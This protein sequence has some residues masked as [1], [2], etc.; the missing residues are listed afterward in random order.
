MDLERACAVF[1]SFWRASLKPVPIE[2]HVIPEH[3]IF[4][5]GVPAVAAQLVCINVEPEAAFHFDSVGGASCGGS[6][7]FSSAVRFSAM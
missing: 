1:R 4:R 5:R 2:G 6:P 3:Y 7:L